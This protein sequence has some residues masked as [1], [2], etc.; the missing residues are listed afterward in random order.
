MM[1]VVLQFT[2]PS[3][4]KRILDFLLGTLRIQ[5]LLTVASYLHFLQVELPFPFEKLS[6]EHGSKYGLLIVV[7][8]HTSLL[9]S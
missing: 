6:S 8:H 2:R 5:G 3:F 9:I 1:H 7:L 4:P